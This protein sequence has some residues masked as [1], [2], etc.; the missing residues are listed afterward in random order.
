M[1]VMEL[2][3]EYN[4]SPEWAYVRLAVKIDLLEKEIAELKKPKRK[5]AKKKVATNGDH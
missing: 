3:K 1:D 5:P 2:K 4:N